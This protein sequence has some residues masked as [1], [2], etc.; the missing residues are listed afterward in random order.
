MIPA[1]QGKL[2]LCVLFRAGKFGG[3]DKQRPEAFGQSREV[4]GSFR[5]TLRKAAAAFLWIFSQKPALSGEK[6]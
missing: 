4:V 1:F 3:G 2:L 6:A 5:E